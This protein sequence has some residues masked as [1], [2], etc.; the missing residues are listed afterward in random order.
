MRPEPE[1]EVVV[2]ELDA[3]SKIMFEKSRMNPKAFISGL[4]RDAQDFLERDN[5]SPM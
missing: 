1:Y 3:L 2:D 5:K 4:N